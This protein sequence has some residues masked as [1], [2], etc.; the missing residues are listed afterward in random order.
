MRLRG[1]YDNPATNDESVV[2]QR[3]YAEMI[4]AIGEGNIES[5]YAQI[6]K[7]DDDNDGIMMYR[8]PIID[9]FINNEDGIKE[10]ID[11]IYPGGYQPNSMHKKSILAT[12]NEKVD[13]W[14]NLI[15]NL[16][17]NEKYNLISCDELC[18]VDDPKKS[19][20]NAD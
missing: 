14:N 8:L 11:F 6:L 5:D 12:T 4:L 20:R 15:Q 19:C 3:N 1:L 9:Y 17:P 13:E 16:N 10:A 2:K 18:E 7:D